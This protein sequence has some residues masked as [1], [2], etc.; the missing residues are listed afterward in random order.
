MVGRLTRATKCRGCGADIAFIKTVGGKSIP[1]DP[2]P[3]Y[4]IQEEDNEKFVTEAGEVKRGKKAHW[5]LTLS[6]QQPEK[7]Y[8][9]HFATCPQADKFRKK[10]KSERVKCR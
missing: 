5:R 10:N 9:P 6:A 8:R 4:F 3:V 1:V 2:D 7:G